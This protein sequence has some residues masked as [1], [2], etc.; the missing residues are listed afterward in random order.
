M[1]DFTMES[2]RITICMGMGCTH[3]RT[4]ENMKVSISRIE[5]MGL[6]FTIGL[7]DECTRGTGWL[8]SSMILGCTGYLI[9][10][11]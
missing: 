7:M 8:G 3:G 6:G 11:K 4:T 1:D 10:V 2:G 9:R 5:N